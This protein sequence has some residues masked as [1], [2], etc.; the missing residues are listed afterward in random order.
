M[1]DL[2]QR[3]EGTTREGAPLNWSPTSL[4]VHIARRTW[5]FE[6]KQPRKRGERPKRWRRRFFHHL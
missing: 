6:Q 2:R 4:G 3:S 5:L 1:A